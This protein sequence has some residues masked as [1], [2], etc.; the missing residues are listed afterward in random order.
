MENVPNPVMVTVSPSASAPVMAVNT[1]L[2]AASAD[3]LDSEAWLATWDAM[4]DFFI[5]VFLGILPGSGRPRSSAG[6]SLIVSADG[7]G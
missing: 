7:F 1:A 5:G 3:A 2:T 4:S 6:D